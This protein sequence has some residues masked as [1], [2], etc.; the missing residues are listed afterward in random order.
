ITACR[1]E[2]RSCS[3]WRSSS[4]AMSRQSWRSRSTLYTNAVLPSPKTFSYEAKES[5][6]QYFPY[7]IEPE[8]QARSVR[9]LIGDPTDSRDPLWES[10]VSSVPIRPTDGSVASATASVGRGGRDQCG[11]Q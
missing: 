6:I 7:G 8:G 4:L 2:T 1:T 5:G 9:K 10:D 11:K 3:F